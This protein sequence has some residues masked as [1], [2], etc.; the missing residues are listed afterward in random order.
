MLAKV[1]SRVDSIYS[2]I[3]EMK[4]DI[5]NISKQVELYSTS[6][7]YLD[8]QMGQMSTTLNQ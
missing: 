6:I 1:L 5:S 7:K 2:R 4:G 8:Y 3:N